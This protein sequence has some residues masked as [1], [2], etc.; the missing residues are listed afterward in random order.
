MWGYQLRVDAA[1]CNS[2][3]SDNEKISLFA[4][5]IVKQIG[6]TSY[7]DPWVVYFGKDNPSVAGFTL[8]QLMETSNITAHFCDY[9]G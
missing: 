2:N 1:R 7:G 5:D 4:E 8:T 9:S 6:M 3:R